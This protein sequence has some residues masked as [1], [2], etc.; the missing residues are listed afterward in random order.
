MKNR[1]EKELD[2]GTLEEINGGFGL[3]SKF[4]VTLVPGLPQKPSQLKNGWAVEHAPSDE[5]T[6][7]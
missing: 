5:D 3:M 7:D 1:Q 4:S 6:S 2:L